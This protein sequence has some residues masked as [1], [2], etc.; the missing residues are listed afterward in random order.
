VA[1]DLITRCG[2]IIDYNSRPGR[3]I[4]SLILPLVSDNT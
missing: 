4:F 1:Q 3:T 2:G